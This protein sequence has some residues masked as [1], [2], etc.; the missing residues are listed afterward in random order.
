MQASIESTELAGPN[1]KGKTKRRTERPT[2]PWVP[3]P[4][5]RSHFNLGHDGFDV[6]DHFGDVLADFYHLLLMFLRFLLLFLLLQVF[7]IPANVFEKFG[8][9]LNAA[10]QIGD[11][12]GNKRKRVLRPSASEVFH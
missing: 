8:P 7:E 12:R 5:L 2:H 10:I 9:L 6:F 4:K 1:R 11:L 3:R